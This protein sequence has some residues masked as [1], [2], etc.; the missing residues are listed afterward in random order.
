MSGYKKR[1]IPNTRRRY[2]NR[3]FISRV[4]AKIAVYLQRLR[5]T[6]SIRSLL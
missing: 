2:I 3:L 5:F 1:I 6:G 4:R